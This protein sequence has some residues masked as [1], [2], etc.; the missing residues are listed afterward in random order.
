MESTRIENRSEMQPVPVY[1][2]SLPNRD[3]DISLVGFWRMVVRR[4][5]FILASVLACLLLAVGYLLMAKWIYRATAHLLPPQQQNVQGLLVDYGDVKDLDFRSYTPEFVYKA[6]LANLKSQGLRREFFDSNNLINHYVLANTDKD[7]N[8]NHVFN[9]VFNKRLE[10]RIDRTDPSFVSMSFS[11]TDPEFAA[12]WLNQFIDL[13]N[14]RTIK[15]LFNDVNAAIQAQIAKVSEQMASK[16]ELAGKRRL[17]KIVSLKEALRVAKVLGIKDTL[18]FPQVSDKAQA[19][20]AVNTAEVPLYMRGTDALETEI[21][22]LESRKSDEPFIRGFRDL[23]ERRAFLE[24]ISV[25]LGS[26]S[27]VTVDDV[28]RAPYRAESPKPVQ[29]MLLAA[30]LGLAAGFGL[31]FVAETVSRFKQAAA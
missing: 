27:A 26:L 23:Q 2:V 30:V 15:Q 25:D 13:A 18:T 20:L 31:A 17:D 29:T 7:V 8:I 6:F 5:G 21:S 19:G 1:I 22:V 12:Q 10:M 11:D 9:D 28:A 14:K 4:K 16:L 3:E 24:G